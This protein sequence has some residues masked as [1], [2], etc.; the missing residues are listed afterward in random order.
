MPCGTFMMRTMPLRWPTC[1]LEDLEHRMTSRSLMVAC[2]LMVWT[3][4]TAAQDEVARNAEVELVRAA[5]DTIRST[6]PEVEWTFPTDMPRSRHAKGRPV[7]SEVLGIALNRD[8][9]STIDSIRVGPCRGLDHCLPPEVQGALAFRVVRANESERRLEATVMRRL[10]SG[11][12]A[13][14]D[15]LA[16]MLPSD[17][18]GWTIGSFGVIRDYQ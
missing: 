6:F 1:A 10:D 7:I 8:L 14:Q 17:R 4:P 5:Y 13:K 12:V 11:V 15:Y 18:G 9:L 3:T 16:V 2:A